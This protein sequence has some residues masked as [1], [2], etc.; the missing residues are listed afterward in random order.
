MLGAGLFVW[1]CL[2]I[3]FVLGMLIW[4]GVVLVTLVW[5]LVIA[6]LLLTLLDFICGYC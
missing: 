4:L 5:V 2:V 1:C 6:V 3:E